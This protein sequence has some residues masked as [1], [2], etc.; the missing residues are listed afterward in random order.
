MSALCNYRRSRDGE[1]TMADQTFGERLK[2]LREQAGLTQ[3][4][5]AERVGMNRFSIAKLEQGLY[6]PSWATV[7]SLARAL[8]VNCTAFE[9]TIEPPSGDKPARPKGRPKKPAPAAE[10]PVAKAEPTGKPKRK[11]GE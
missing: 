1:P 3:A 11:K 7:Q 2:A 5:L 4:A 10:E 6:G 8:A 9:G